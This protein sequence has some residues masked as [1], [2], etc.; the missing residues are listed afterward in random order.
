MFDF[1][2]KISLLAISYEYITPQNPALATGKWG[3]IYIY[4]KT[5]EFII[6]EMHDHVHCYEV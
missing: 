3:P 4:I 1:S 2:S 5:Y 6:I